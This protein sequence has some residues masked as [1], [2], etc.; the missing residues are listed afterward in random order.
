MTKK[1]DKIREFIF[2]VVHY[3]FKLG[4]QDLFQSFF[5]MQILITNA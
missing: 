5:V 3:P 2:L 4:A 1:L